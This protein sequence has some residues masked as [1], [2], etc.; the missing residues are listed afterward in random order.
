M[1]SRFFLFNRLYLLI[2]ALSCTSSQGQDITGMHPAA[3][4][5]LLK[6][7]PA[8]IEGWELTRSRGSTDL[9]MWLE[10][11]VTREFV[12]EKTTPT[13]NLDKVPQ[14]CVRLSILDTGE[15]GGTD[16]DLFADFTPAVSKEGGYEY[17]FLAGL[18]AIITSLSERELEAC[19]LV[20]NRFIITIA[21]QELPTSELKTWLKRFDL[22]KLESLPDTQKRTLP[23]TFQSVH[24]DEL[25]VEKSR[26]VV[27]GTAIEAIDETE[28][29]DIDNEAE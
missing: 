13:T 1:T 14:P 2:L 9:G 29:P 11:R 26:K 24:I 19:L 23:K 6:A 5:E 4:A 21:L 15:A 16:L 20:D 10:S 22:K 7:L 3:P 27:V 28:D 8:K 17:R 12:L 25:A 18:P